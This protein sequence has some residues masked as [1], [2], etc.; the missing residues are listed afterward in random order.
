MRTPAKSSRT[1]AA[2]TLLTAALLAAAVSSGVIA[3][4]QTPGAVGALKGTDGQAAP[5]A[6]DVSDAFTPAFAESAF[7][8]RNASNFREMSAAYGPFTQEQIARLNRDRFLIVPQREGMRLPYFSSGSNRYDE[9]LGIFEGLGGSESPDARSPEQARF[10]GPDVVLHAFHKYFSERLKE[11]ER[12]TLARLVE[13]MLSG[14]WENALAL[15]AEAPEGARAAWDLALAQMAVP[16]TLIET[17]APAPPNWRL[18]DEDEEA[19]KTPADNL[20]A[21]LANFRAREGELPEGLRAA[22]RGALGMIYAQGVAPPEPGSAAAADS[23]S[24]PAAALGLVPSYNAQTVDWTQFLPRSHYAETSESRAY[25]RASIWLGQL[26]WTR[27]DPGAL[28]QLVAWA[29]ALAGPGG[30]LFAKACAAIAEAEDAVPANPAEA[31]RSV[32]RI[33]ALFAGLPD[34]PSLM[35]VLELVTAGGAPPG[36][37]A[38]GDAAYLSGLAPR[39]ARLAPPVESFKAFRGGGYR[40]KGVVTV[41]PQRFTVPWLIA[42]ELTI[43][44]GQVRER[45]ARASGGRAGVAAPGAQA[46]ASADGPLPVV[47]SGLYLAQAL[48]S[49]YAESL[50]GRELEARRSL[51]AP[52]DAGGEAASDLIEAKRAALAAKARWLRAALDRVPSSDWNGSVGS[53]WFNVLRT[54]SATYGE[55][56]PIYMRGG[57]F[58]AKQ[59]ETLLGSYTELKHDTLLYD[60]PNYA[61][62]G[63]GG[64]DIDPPPVPKGFVEPNLEFWDAMAEALRATEEA[65]RSNGLF[66]DHQERYG[67]L[68]Y[69]SEK[70]DRLRGIARTELA[71][72]RPSE[73]DYEFLRTFTIQEMAERPGGGAWTDPETFLS[74]LVVDVQTINAVG[75]DPGGVLHEGLGAPSLILVLVGNDGDQRMTVGMAF[76][77]YEFLIREIRRLTD[78]AWKAAAY[79][80]FDIAEGLA[81]VPDPALPELPAKP[82]WYDPIAAGPR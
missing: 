20:E 8:A 31:W 79:R 69:F 27:D 28:P 15:R 16:L 57:A 40:G 10:V 42:S 37:G 23:G 59:L 3:A 63:N 78:S 72:G 58:G 52:D 6:G 76:N 74:G 75:G 48:G 22:V 2:L 62:M 24:D 29:A 47:F 5:P 32:M 34:D 18:D 56:Y 49:E 46:A 39:M 68:A 53:A 70:V 41:L 17:R 11:V 71:G 21:A 80:G 51:E 64:Y 33:T 66:P 77:H 61:E 13:A 60:K 36:P 81:A 43:E 44:A 14:L 54:L 73:D 4:A 25:F 7:D 26:G 35:D 30:E 19:D 12:G 82:F 50:S 38:P 1:G 9:M 67:T 55:G 45:A 65:F